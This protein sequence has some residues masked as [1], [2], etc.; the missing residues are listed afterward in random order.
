MLQECLLK[1]NKSS[2]KC[3]AKGLAK[4]RAVKKHMFFP[5]AKHDFF[6]FDLP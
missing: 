2:L 5:V 4:K 3:K 6:H 1:L